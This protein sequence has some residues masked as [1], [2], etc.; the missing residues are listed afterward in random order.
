MNIAARLRS[1]EGPEHGDGRAVL[2][3]Q[4]VSNDRDGGF[5]ASDPRRVDA[6]HRQPDMA[7]PSPLPKSGNDQGASDAA[8]DR[9][10]VGR[11]AKRPGQYPRRHKSKD[12]DKRPKGGPANRRRY[13]PGTPCYAALDLGTNNCRLLL[14]V[15][16]GRSFR[17]V[18]S[19]S[20]I[21]R[22]GEELGHTGRLS[23]QAMDR[24]LAALRTCQDK[25][26]AHSV[27]RGRFITTEACRRADNGLDFLARVE[28]ETGLALEVIN[29]RTEAQLAV[30]G[31]ASLVEH[32]AKNV[33]LFD[34]GG[35]ST[36][37]VWLDL[38]ERFTGRRKPLANYIRSWASLPLGVVNL[39]ERHGGKDVTADDYQRM[40]ET[41]DA[42]L[43]DF[44]LSEELAEAVGRGDGHMLGTSGTV[45]TLAGVHLELPRYDLRRVDGA[46]LSRDQITHLM[47]KIRTM[48]YSE[49]VSNPCIGRERADLVVAGC[50]ILDAIQQRW[51]LQ[52]LRVA[53][54]GLREGILMGLMARDGVFRRPRHRGKP[55]P[56]AHQQGQ[57]NG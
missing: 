6:P 26:A 20:K 36:E 38:R 48:G 27:K 41:V 40:I 30:S 19:Y 49:R 13:S 7:F 31:C 34:I 47:G 21:V 22:L 51:P 8:R 16:N 42:Q 35:G 11:P 37:I 15:P 50:A 43:D 5:P 46:W 55:K 57:G 29:G 9:S 17:V 52:R 56:P 3:D 32:Q 4:T 53:D 12:P 10:P 23:E 28:Q 33:V 18:D 1:A 14:A 54:R 2:A 44:P 45:T 39:S 24:T 25:L